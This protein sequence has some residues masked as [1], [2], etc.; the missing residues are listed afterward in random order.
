MCSHFRLDHDDE[1]KFEDFPGYGLQLKEDV[2]EGDKALAL[3]YQNQRLMVQYFHFGMR[4]YD[5]RIL[6][7]RLESVDEKDLFKEAFQFRRA[8]FPASVFFE[9][10]NGKAEHGFQG[11]GILYLAGCYENNEFVLLTRPAND[12]VGRFHKRMP[13]I[14]DRKK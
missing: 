11:E 14:L 8:V 12:I 4:R 5:K 3:V 13:L 6:N 2:F 7:A 10:D 1:E 9:K